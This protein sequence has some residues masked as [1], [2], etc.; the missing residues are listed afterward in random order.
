M[1]YCEGAKCDR[2]EAPDYWKQRI[3]G[4]DQVHLVSLEVVE[5]ILG[6]CEVVGGALPE[7][8]KKGLRAPWIRKLPFPAVETARQLPGCEYQLDIV[9]DSRSP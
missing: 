8:S 1:G 9:S 5:H 3:L 7:M 6:A 4:A 2:S